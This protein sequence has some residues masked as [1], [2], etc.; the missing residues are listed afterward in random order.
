MQVIG[1][2]VHKISQFHVPANVISEKS[3]QEL[4]VP[5]YI[6][7][8]EHGEIHPHLCSVYL[9]YPCAVRDSSPGKGYAQRDCLFPH[10]LVQSKQFLTDIPKCQLEA[11]NFILWISSQ[12]NLD[13]VMLATKTN[14]HHIHIA[15]IT[16]T[17]SSV[18]L[19]TR[20]HDGGLDSS[21]KGSWQCLPC[22]G[23]WIYSHV[24]HYVC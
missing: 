5:S 8:E 13:S 2:I 18:Q 17:P 10:S 20:Q 21:L 3:R 7:C 9:F 4:K 24:I 12:I 6:P 15:K 19:L 11:D 16:L 23:F 1:E 22:L 14:P